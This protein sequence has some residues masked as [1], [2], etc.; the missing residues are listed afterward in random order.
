[1]SFFRRVPP[2]SPRP[3]PLRPPVDSPMKQRARQ[4]RQRALQA[5]FSGRWFSIQLRRVT[6]G[7][8]RRS[9]VVSTPSIWQRFTTWYQLRRLRKRPTLQL[10][11]LGNFLNPTDEG[12]LHASQAAALLLRSA[13][14]LL[15][16]FTLF[17]LLID[18]LPL[19][20]SG[21]PTWYLDQIARFGES[22]PVFI[23]IF[24][25]GI[26]S[27]ALGTASSAS[28][29]FRRRYNS[30]LRFFTIL[31]L[32]LVP[33]Q[34]ALSVWFL[35]ASY[36]GAR[37]QLNAIRVQSVALISAAEQQTTSAGFV[38]F[39]QSRQL[40]ANLDAIKTSPLA[41]VK[42]SFIQNV[43]A[44]RSLQE[45]S[46]SKSLRTG[47]LRFVLSSGKLL[48]SLIL[49]CIFLVGASRIVSRISSDFISPTTD[50]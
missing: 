25:F 45:Q 2:R 35:S 18:A 8:Q 39:L 21:G 38:A 23:L 6:V 31:S 19:Q 49:F 15:L 16:L 10:F 4:E 43:K 26:V 22:V 24:A 9:R 48:G 36:A 3:R 5:F 34:I 17:G 20:L 46:I 29:F 14:L 27:L 1:M 11:S 33:T 30:L 7:R 42:Q 44:N 12:L 47:V 13:A 41:S 37:T 40:T 28:S 50:S 32:L